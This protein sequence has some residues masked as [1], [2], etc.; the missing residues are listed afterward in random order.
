[1]AAISA[2][3]FAMDAAS[4]SLCM[5]SS[6]LLCRQNHLQR[7]L[8]AAPFPGSVHHGPCATDQGELVCAQKRERKARV[9]K[10]AGCCPHTP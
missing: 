3:F 4:T 7:S 5:A 10:T 8:L 9:G 6:A 1:M 2:V